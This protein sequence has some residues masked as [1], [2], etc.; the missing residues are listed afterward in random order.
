MLEMLYNLLHRLN[1]LPWTLSHLLSLYPVRTALDVRCR[2]G[3][4]WVLD[5]DGAPR[6]RPTT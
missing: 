6:R 1:R 4:P 2:F 3:A 5:H